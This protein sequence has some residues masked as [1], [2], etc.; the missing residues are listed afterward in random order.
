MIRLK[1]SPIMLQLLQPSTDA[2]KM[3]RIPVGA[4]FRK[5]A[6]TSLK[7]R[8]KTGECYPDEVF[9]QAVID[10]RNKGL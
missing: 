1:Q 3:Y 10:A 6:L 2:L 7:V 9:P 4:A 8:L 5:G